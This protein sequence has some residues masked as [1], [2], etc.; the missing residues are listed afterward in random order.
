[1][2]PSAGCTP[3]WMLGCCVPT[4]RLCR[5]CTPPVRSPA[6]VAVGCTAIAPWKVPSWAGVC[7]PVVPPVGPLPPRSGSPLPP[8]CT[9]TGGTIPRCLF[10][11]EPRSEDES[12][13]HSATECPVGAQKQPGP[14]RLVPA[15]VGLSETVTC[16]HP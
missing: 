13:P 5:V 4:A 7:S 11:P 16:S 1:A 6:S 9:G 14:D 8:R 2:R 15:I 10:C 12:H 3:I